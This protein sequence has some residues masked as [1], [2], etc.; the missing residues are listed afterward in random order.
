MVRICTCIQWNPYTKDTLGTEKSVLYREVS[1]L[2]RSIDTRK[3][4]FGKQIVSFIE[5]CPLSS[6]VH[7]FSLFLFGFLRCSLSRHHSIGL[8]IQNTYLALFWK[9][10]C[11][12][13]WSAKWT[14]N[15]REI[16]SDIL[17]IFVHYVTRVKT[18]FSNNIS[19][20][21]CHG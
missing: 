13:S 21:T 5:T 15:T 14:F 10:M 7:S 6:T 19:K 17:L 20:Y 8:T 2:Q 1:F 3:A 12:F 4:I 16:L 11:L 18:S 9:N